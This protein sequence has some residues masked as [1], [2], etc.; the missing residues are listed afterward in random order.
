M[1]AAVR[2][3]AVILGVVI[4][5]FGAL[6]AYLSF[7]FDPNDYRD[8]IAQEAE[9]ATGRKLVIEG[10]LRLSVFPW[11]G[12]EIGQASL[13]N[14]PGFGDAPFASVGQVELRARLM[15]LLRSEIEVA[16]VVL[17]E[18]K[19][20]LVVDGQGMTNWG[21][22]AGGDKGPSKASD[23]PAAQGGRAVAGLVVSGV[24]V[25]S[26]RISYTD[27]RN[28]TEY[29]I[30][31][32]DLKTGEVRPGS[33]FPLE[34][35]FDVSVS[36][37][38]LVGRV[39]IAGQV[40]FELAGPVADIE[41]FRLRFKGE[42]PALP[43]GSTDVVL[44]S[45]L[46]VDLAAGT[47]AIAGLELDAY[48]VKASGS[49]AA[50][51][52]NDAPAVSGVLE[53]PALDPA[54]LLAALGVEVPKTSD[55]AVLKRASLK[56]RVEASPVSAALR[57]L[58]AVLDDTTL[59]GEIA[60][61]DFAKQSLRF[62]LALDSINVDR[63]LPPSSR[64]K[65][66]SSQPPSGERAGPE[67]EGMDPAVLRGRDVA[68]KMRIGRLVASGATMTDIN[69]ELRVQNGV[70][71]MSP[72]SAALYEGRYA[73]NITVDG[74]GQ[75]LAVSLDESLKGVQVGPLLRDLSGAEERLTGNANVTARL[76]LRGND[77]E[78]M[79]RTLGGNVDFSFLN[80]AVKGIN[81]A[82]YLRQAQAR[83]AGKPVP[84]TNEP[85]QTDFSQLT[86]TLQIANGVARNDDLDVRSPLLRVGGA[87]SV[88]IPEESIDYTVRASVV[89]TLSGQGGEGLE[90]LKGV[91]VPI[92]VAGTFDKPSFGLDMNNLV[93]D[94]VKQQAQEKLKGAVQERL[95]EQGGGD[96]K[97]TLQK[98]L[99]DLLRR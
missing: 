93:S 37:P 50:R 89:A 78:A 4:V 36:E 43:G 87:G 33:R 47:A 77:P 30:D 62:D 90:S 73:G 64:D 60:V 22:L 32:L 98:G 76:Q 68:G 48:G 75:T 31:R 70:L 97:E 18:L 53:V 57:D 69:V 56:A 83:I 55:A 41:D 88:N 21:D 58:T 44:S 14:A 1:K 13:G 25:D 19:L 82:Q 59:T 46:A 2:I 16:R 95:Q 51:G 72:L 71:R 86:G 80:G 45:K 28:G 74:R 92:K 61:T 9:K 67:A 39:D 20:D 29:V 23:S 94:A 84:Q 52:L 54:A 17:R 79:K 8:R 63:Y 7:V 27:R 96:L 91:T 34:L 99:G 35:G 66:K 38:Q 26:A 15:P 65:D 12:V 40:L 5:L 49:F 3:V 42:G 11:I 81:V 85:N 24:Q 6:A 10:D